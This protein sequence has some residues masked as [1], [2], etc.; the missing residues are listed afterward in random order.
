MASKPLKSSPGTPCRKWP[1][2]ETDFSPERG[3]CPAC[4]LRLISRQQSWSKHPVE[5]PLHFMRPGGRPDRNQPTP[6]R[7][8]QGTQ[9]APCPARRTRRPHPRRFTQRLFRDDWDRVGQ[10]YRPR[11]TGIARNSSLGDDLPK[12]WVHPI[13]R[14]RKSRVGGLDSSSSSA[15]RREPARR[16]WFPSDDPGRGP[17]AIPPVP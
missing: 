7:L 4:D 17:R 2:L 15:F 6:A 1:G 16:E 11:T 12:Q 3:L 5:A 9:H 13:D 14:P 8:P 10:S